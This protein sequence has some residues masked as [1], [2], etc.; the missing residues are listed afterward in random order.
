MVLLF[1][2]FLAI[3][4]VAILVAVSQQIF[5]KKGFWRNFFIV[6]GLILLAYGLIGVGGTTGIYALGEDASAFFL[7]A[8]V[9]GGSPEGDQIGDVVCPEATVL[10]NGVCIQVSGGGATFQPTAAY[11]SRDKYGT[12]VITGTS[13]YKVNG[14]SATTTAYS[15]VNVG[16]SV[17][18][19]VENSSYWVSPD[20]MKTNAGVNTFEALGFA[21]ST[22]TL[23]LYDSVNRQSN[24]ISDSYNTSMGANDQA[25][26]E[27]TYQGTAEGS[28]GPFGGLLVAEYNSTIS[29]VICNGPALATVPYHLTYTVSN[30]ANTYKSWGYGPSLDDGSGSV[31]RINCQFKNGA[32][33]AGAGSLYHFKFVPANYYI[34]NDGDIV[35]DTEKFDNGD[36][37]RTG[38]IINQPSISGYWAA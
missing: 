30:T 24:S 16:D 38:S 28:A 13:Y 5:K 20:S 26:V 33:A 11:S 9:A 14:K 36:T 29:S 18:Y 12:T 22:A 10:S 7:T 3:I 32:V 35:L 6:I 8:A 2:I 19:W 1:Q 4:G 27:I 17:T 15:N 23:S 25:N 34:T 31:Q 21:N 37:T